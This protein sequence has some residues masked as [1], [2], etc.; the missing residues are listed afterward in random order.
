MSWSKFGSHLVVWGGA[1][2]IELLLL[3]GYLSLPPSFD[4]LRWMWVLVI[5]GAVHF[6]I[7]H[8]VLKRRTRV[9]PY[10]MALFVLVALG[11]RLTAIPLAPSLSDDLYRN[12]WDGRTQAAGIDP[13]AHAPA[14]PAV[15]HLREG[16]VWPS[17]NHPE[18]RTIYP[19][20]ALYFS[21]AAVFLE[22][23]VPA[24]ANRP[25][26]AWK[27]VMLTVEM[28]GALLL[29]WGLYRKN[30]GIAFLLYGWSP[31]A[32][33]EFYASGHVDAAGV[34]LLAGATGL[35]FLR[36]RILSGVFLAA[37][38][39]TKLLVLP[40]LIAFV[41]LRG[42]RKRL[43]GFAIAAVL[44]SLPFWNSG[45]EAIDSLRTYQAR[46][47]FNG[48]VHRLLHVDA[49]GA[50]PERIERREWSKLGNAGT[51]AQKKIG[52]ALL[53]LLVLAGTA[54][55]VRAGARP[56]VIAVWSLGVFLLVQPTIHPWYLTWLLPLLTLHYVRAFL[57]WTVT[58]PFSYE[59]LLAQR[60]GQG[61]IEN[62]P[63]Q[64]ASLLPVLFF[65]IW[66]L[67]RRDFGMPILEP[68]ADEETD[69][70]AF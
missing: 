18:L 9:R 58:I 21:R 19:P 1:V 4:A 67:H 22:E 44:L 65:M 2:L 37:S 61:W 46:W 45:A 69:R 63:L 34:G 53:S 10:H 33:I 59:V 30:R 16:I 3:S 27:L 7:V 20:V 29:A 17:I 15:A 56:A 70:L 55:A 57:V 38:F 52:R 5:G 43:A 11:F 49:W 14:D 47:E 31:L 51:E 24:L 8:H 54:A 23:R 13:Y 26:L 48:V 35:I 50:I 12:I 60:L 25:V 39:L 62:Y 64:A 28:S 66:D 42:K 32:V 6:A 40:S 36:Q 41:A 68:T